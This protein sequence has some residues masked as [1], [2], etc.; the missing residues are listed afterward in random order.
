MDTLR[1]QVGRAR[2]DDGSGT[3]RRFGRRG[4]G[5]LE[6]EV[7]VKLRGASYGDRAVLTRHLLDLRADHATR[8]AHYEK[9]E[10]EQFPDPTVLDEARLDQWLVLRG[11]LRM[12]RFWID[13]TTDYLNA[14][15]ER[16]EASA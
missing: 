16:T 12:E 9:F 3:A 7:A 6:R 4:G 13:W 2:L 1:R 14:H 8:L 10:R 15:D 11:G 5:R